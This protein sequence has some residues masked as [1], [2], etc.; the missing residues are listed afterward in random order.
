M[1]WWL[2]LKFF[3]LFRLQSYSSG[4]MSEVNFGEFRSYDDQCLTLEFSFYFVSLLS[5]RRLVC[6]CRLARHL[7]LS[8][9]FQKSTNRVLFTLLGTTASRASR[10]SPLSPAHR[11]RKFLVV[12]SPFTRHTHHIPIFRFVT[13]NRFQQKTSSA[14]RCDILALALTAQLFL[15][16]IVLQCITLPFDQLRYPTCQID[17]LDGFSLVVFCFYQMRILDDRRHSVSNS[18]L[19]TER[20][21][22]LLEFGG[23]RFHTISRF[24]RRTDPLLA[25]F[26][27][28]QFRV[29]STSFAL[30]FSDRAL[31]RKSKPEI[32][33][34]QLTF[35]RIYQ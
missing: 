20:I 34:L 22:G 15:G 29:Q 13:S 11:H 30:P 26:A 8:S 25:L 23:R 32:A 1:I 16:Q 4:H 5:K 21:A 7:S 31:T 6:M 12:F 10:E 2:P 9:R 14:G 28:D 24:F 3:D 18:M 35:N 17:S 33:I 19:C 27:L